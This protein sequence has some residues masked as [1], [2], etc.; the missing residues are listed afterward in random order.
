MKRLLEDPRIASELRADLLRSRSAG[1]D[2]QAAAKLLQLRA[3]FSENPPAVPA[4]D[5]GLNAS[6]K[7][8]VGRGVHPGWKLAVLAALGGGAGL[9]AY[10]AAPTP[11]R[12]ASAE[13]PRFSPEAVQVVPDD[14]PTVVD[15]PP[16]I[17]ASPAPPPAAD[18]AGPSAA[19]AVPEAT[20]RR[21]SESNSSRREIA[22]LVRMRALLE[23]DP[24]AAYRLAQR[25]E[26][27]F[28][29]GILAQERQALSIVA[30]AR[31]GASERARTQA[32]QFF[33]RYPQSPLRE[34]V[35]AALQR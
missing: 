4:R 22:Q 21:V 2:Y 8:A 6:L 20:P 32:R 27:E 11:D 28:P 9:L 29:R 34:S 26:R 7:H 14:A 30:L 15:Q 18:P 33:A 35:E 1:Q 24:A 12:S 5:K 31:T 3:A 13:Q 19:R 10:S 17:A 25:A 16:L 23:R